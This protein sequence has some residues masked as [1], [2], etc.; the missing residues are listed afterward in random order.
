MHKVNELDSFFNAY[1]D[2]FIYSLDN[3]LILN[4]YSKRVV[5]FA[6]GESLLELGLGHGYTSVFFNKHFKKH[7]VIDGSLKIIEN[8]RK[9]FDI[10]HE[11]NIVHSLFEEYE[12]T[13]KFDNIVMGF[14]LEHVDNPNIIIEKYLKFLKPNGRLFIAVPNCEALNKRIGY[15]AGLI[16]DMKELSNAD[17]KLG[18][19]RLYTVQ[20]LRELIE[21]YN[22]EIKRIE[23]IFL[24][25]ITTQQ[26]I[27]L[28]L[29]NEILEA[30]LKVGVDY[31][32]LSVGILMEVSTKNN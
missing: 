10:N 20:S 16:K 15:E 29:S 18:H 3:E 21:E 26:I 8:F 14:I 22:L 7:I 9:K 13:E 27:D 2:G 28:K 17:K 30:M 6:K 12:T 11:I 23:G 32:E 4:W 5:K 19:Q 24:K 31:P 1:Q 25:P